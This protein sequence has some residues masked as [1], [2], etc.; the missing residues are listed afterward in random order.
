ML[1]RGSDIA[2]KEGVMEY[3]RFCQGDFNE[4]QANK[5][6]TAVIANQS[7]HHIVNLEGVFSEVRASLGDEGVFIISDMIGRNGHQRWPE[8][9][10]VVHEFWRELPKEYKYNHQLRRTERLYENWD[11]STEGF[12]GIRAQDILPLL[13]EHFNFEVFVAFGNVIDIFVDRGFGHNFNPNKPWDTDFIDRVHSR[14]EQLIRS[15]EITPTHMMAVLRKSEVEL[16][17]YSRGLTP[18]FCVRKPGEL[19]D[20]AANRKPFQLAR[21]VLRAVSHLIAR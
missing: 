20:M 12:E 4:W 10:Q 6:Y 18:S 2:A 17:F 13:I 15:G 19:D 8:A 9:L 11:C 3:M 16:P 21:K 1:E 7:L 5:Q 14:D